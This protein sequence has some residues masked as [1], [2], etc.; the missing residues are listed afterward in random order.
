MKSRKD[1]NTT[2][3]KQPTSQLR[4]MSKVTR[5]DSSRFGLPVIFLERSFLNG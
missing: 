3:D 1:T 4:T 5:S 2:L